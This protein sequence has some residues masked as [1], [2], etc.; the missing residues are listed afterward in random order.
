MENNYFLLILVFLVITLASLI[1]Y[2]D[3]KSLPFTIITG[4]F[5]TDFSNTFAGCRCQERNRFITDFNTN[6]SNSL[7]AT[8]IIGNYYKSINETCSN[9]ECYDL[10]KG[11]YNCFCNEP[12]G[13]L[14]NNGEFYRIEC[15]T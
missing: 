4:D 13:V 14:R 15:N 9:P 7:I 5:C 11:F 10:G 8:N 1:N 3:L 12:I 2:Y 6:I